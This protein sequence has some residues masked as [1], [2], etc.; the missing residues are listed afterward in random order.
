MSKRPQCSLISLNIERDRHLERVI[1]FIE[2]EKPDVLCLQEVMEQDFWDFRK[3]FGFCDGF[4]APMSLS[5]SFRDDR[6]FELMP[7]GIGLLSRLPVSGTHVRYYYGNP[8]DPVPVFKRFPDGRIDQTTI[9]KMFLWATVMRGDEAFTIGTT[10][11]TWSEK[12]MA[13]D[14][15]RKDADAM[16]ATL[17]Q[18]PEI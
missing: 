15:Q 1:P 10:H 16:L 4:Y 12:G 13:D 17:A 9:H 6:E 5:R 7:R 11:F 3:R 2:R 14:E 8:N 18:F